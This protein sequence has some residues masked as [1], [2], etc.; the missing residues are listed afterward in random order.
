VSTATMSKKQYHKQTQNAVPVKPE[1]P[2]P[3]R[4]VPPS[5]SACTA[6]RPAGDEFTKVYSIHRDSQHVTRYCRCEF[7]GNTFKHVEKTN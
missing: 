5:C 1:E 6:L 4:Y 3:R 7:C 2:K